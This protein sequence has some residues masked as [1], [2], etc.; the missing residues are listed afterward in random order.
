MRLSE[1][2]AARIESLV[3]YVVRESGITIEE[4]ARKADLLPTV[5]DA[6]FNGYRKSTW[7]LGEA[8]RFAEALGIQLEDVRY[9]QV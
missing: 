9:S 5:T 1:E 3:R 4:L 2:L 6:Y 8:V 7:S